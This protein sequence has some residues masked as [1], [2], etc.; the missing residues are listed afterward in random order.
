MGHG[1]PVAAGQLCIRCLMRTETRVAIA[2][3]AVLIALL[4]MSAAYDKPQWYFRLVGIVGLVL[5]CVGPVVAFTYG[6]R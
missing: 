1:R 5:F 3:L 2:G 6:R 4:L